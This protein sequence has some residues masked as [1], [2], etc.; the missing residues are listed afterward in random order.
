MTNWFRRT[1]MLLLA[2]GAGCLIFGDAAQLAI[3]LYNLSTIALVLL[4]VD[5]LLDTR[6]KWGLFPSLDLDA[7]IKNAISGTVDTIST[8]PPLETRRAPNPIACALIFVGVVVLTAVI[9]CLAVPSARAAGIPERAKPL[10][11]QLSSALDSHWPG[12]P[13]RHLPAGQVEQESAWKERATLST[14]RELGRGLVQMTIAFD[15]KGKERF[16]IYRSAV[17]AR[18]LSGWDWQKDPYN[19]SYQLTFL[20][21]QDRSNFA[22]MRPFFVN[23][24]EAWKATLVSYN[25]G[26]GRV[27]LRRAEAKRRGIPADRWDGGLSVA[28]SSKENAILYGRP[29]HEAVNE[30]PRVIF[31]RSAKYQG[32]V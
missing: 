17:R 18:A 7:A 27:L 11:P 15:S 32:L 29:L 31:Q 10:L 19:V 12:A 30:Y 1:W 28:W 6:E 2:I 3:T 14:S 20:V 16:N 23:E 8:N 5:W 24:T 13:L 4:L 26:P 21:L 9:L 25:A 22:Q